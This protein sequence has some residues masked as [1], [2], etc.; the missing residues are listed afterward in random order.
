M[1]ISSTEPPPGR[2]WQA[3]LDLRPDVLDPGVTRERQGTLALNSF[4]PGVCLRVVRGGDHRAA[5]E[6]ARPDQEVAHLG[7]DLAGVDAR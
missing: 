2:V 7:G 4:T 1:S 6:L 5:V 3:R